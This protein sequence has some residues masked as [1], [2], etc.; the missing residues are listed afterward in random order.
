MK[1]KINCILWHKDWFKKFSSSSSSNENGV[2]QVQF[3]HHCQNLCEMLYS[4]LIPMLNLTLFFR[5]QSINHGYYLNQSDFILQ[6]VYD[7]YFNRNKRI[8][9]YGNLFAVFF[10]FSFLHFVAIKST[11]DKNQCSKFILIVYQINV[12]HK[13][14]IFSVW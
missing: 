6:A 3:M 9:I 2:N 13:F 8:R 5:C 1:M 10:C 11:R 4:I 7:H 14:D 12:E